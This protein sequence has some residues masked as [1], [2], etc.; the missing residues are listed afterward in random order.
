MPRHQMP[1][2]K[3]TDRLDSSNSA[4]ELRLADLFVCGFAFFLDD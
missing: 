2:M 3:S 4:D 1:A